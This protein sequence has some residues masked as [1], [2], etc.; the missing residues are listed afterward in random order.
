MGVGWWQEQQRPV[1]QSP[2]TPVG[3]WLPLHDGDGAPPAGVAP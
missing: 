3:D 2:G 1:Q